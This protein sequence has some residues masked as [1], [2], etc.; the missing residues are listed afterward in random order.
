MVKGKGKGKGAE[1]KK[2]TGSGHPKADRQQRSPRPGYYNDE[3]ANEGAESQGHYEGGQIQI[4]SRGGDAQG[5]YYTDVL[6]T[7]EYSQPSHDR[8][9]SY[10]SWNTYDTATNAYARHSSSR[11]SHHQPRSGES[12]QYGTQ[13]KGVHTLNFATGFGSGARR[14][15][16]KEGREERSAPHGVGRIGR[17]PVPVPT[18]M[19]AA[20]KA[21]NAAPRTPQPKL[22]FLDLVTD[23]EAALVNLKVRSH[24]AVR[25]RNPRSYAE[26]AYEDALERCEGKM[27]VLRKWK[28]DYVAEQG[29]RCCNIISDLG[30]Q[31]NEV[32][33]ENIRGCVIKAKEEAGRRRGMLPGNRDGS[34]ER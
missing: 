13:W 32:I 16:R 1:S 28:Y 30:N 23:F 20:A 34:D 3:V 4:S 25:L 14:S 27:R 17:G 2:K 19:V 10:P 31:L 15:R 29:R 18:A 33:A 7:Y 5:I 21:A 11:S 24:R 26:Q 8:Q 12:K 22:D 6:Q 9:F